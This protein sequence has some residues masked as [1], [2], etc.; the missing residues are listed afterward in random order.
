MTLVFPKYRF[1][2][3]RSNEP[4]PEPEPQDEVIVVGSIDENG[5]L[6]TNDSTATLLFGTPKPLQNFTLKASFDYF[7][8]GSTAYYLVC[9]VLLDKQMKH[10]DDT[11]PQYEINF[12]V[13]NLKLGFYVGTGAYNDGYDYNP[14]L[15]GNYQYSPCE[16]TMNVN[17]SEYSTDT[18][19]YELAQPTG[20]VRI[21]QGNND[22]TQPTTYSKIGKTNIIPKDAKIL[23]FKLQNFGYE[24]LRTNV[25][26]S[27]LEINSV[28]Y[29]A[30]P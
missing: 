6:A 5:N 24:R 28:K 12:A 13:T 30:K 17:F 18:S 7:R 8:Y 26:N 27:Y 9:Q 1:V 22:Y 19:Y 2:I 14:N 21:K 29:Y 20:Q 4:E 10:S 11:A 16:Y 25:N 3:N 15:G 23:G